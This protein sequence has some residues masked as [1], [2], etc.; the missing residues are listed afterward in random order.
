[1]EDSVRITRALALEPALGLV[2]RVLVEV[3]FWCFYSLRPSFTLFALF[4]FAFSTV[5]LEIL[6][7]DVKS[8]RSTREKKTDYFTSDTYHETK[9]REPAPSGLAE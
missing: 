1:M 3:G 7:L 8:V 9:I 4:A 5:L 2:E 6:F